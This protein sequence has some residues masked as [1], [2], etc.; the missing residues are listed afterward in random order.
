M[1]QG[2]A[3]KVL[4]LGSKWQA[5]AR[6]PLNETQKEA[7]RSSKCEVVLYFE[8]ISIL[9]NLPRWDQE[10]SSHLILHEAGWDRWRKGRRCVAEHIPGTTVVFG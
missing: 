4:G 9:L 8:F 2:H 1:R 7:T 3:R 10:S 6:K 5:I